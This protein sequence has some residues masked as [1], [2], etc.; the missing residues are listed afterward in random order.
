MISNN[1]HLTLKHTHTIRNKQHEQES[2]EKQHIQTLKD[3]IY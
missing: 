2:A 3:F 1:Y